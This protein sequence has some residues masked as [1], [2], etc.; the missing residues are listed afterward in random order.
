MPVGLKYKLESIQPAMGEGAPSSSLGRPSFSWLRGYAPN[1][2]VAIDICYREGI[3]DDLI[4][5]VIQAVKEVQC[6]N[7]DPELDRLEGLQPEEWRDVSERM[8]VSLDD[9][10][11]EA[12]CAA[13]LSL[14]EQKFLIARGCYDHYLLADQL[15]SALS[16]GSKPWSFEPVNYRFNWKAPR[17]YRDTGAILFAPFFVLFD[18]LAPYLAEIKAAYAAIRTAGQI[19]GGIPVSRLKRVTGFAQ[20]TMDYGFFSFVCSNDRTIL[21][22]GSGGDERIINAKEVLPEFDFLCF[23]VRSERFCTIE[24]LNIRDGWRADVRVAVDTS[25]FGGFLAK[26][27]R[28]YILQAVSPEEILLKAKMWHDSIEPKIQGIGVSVY[29]ALVR[30]LLDRQEIVSITDLRNEIGLPDL[31]IDPFSVCP[32]NVLVYAPG[33]KFLRPNGVC[34]VHREWVADKEHKR[35]RISLDRILTP[36]YTIDLKAAVEKAALHAVSSLSF[37]AAGVIF[38]AD[39]IRNCCEKSNSHGKRWIQHQLEGS[40]ALAMQDRGLV[41]IQSVIFDPRR[42]P[43]VLKN[44]RSIRATKKEIRKNANQIVAEFRDRCEIQSI[45]DRLFI[46]LSI[47]S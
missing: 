37:R 42:W 4:C 13:Y 18:P 31:L 35:G 46:E 32:G 3:L 1:A 33:E 45:L 16:Y 25:T 23:H 19:N 6:E 11:V 24:G 30:L 27:G 14:A 34:F 17:V 29:K 28:D 43:A 21:R 7:N 39:V 40:V 5:C 12:V 47:E 10:L 36:A 38:L 26:H 20:Q 15:L 44:P 2:Y 41:K 9:A 8:F 22:I